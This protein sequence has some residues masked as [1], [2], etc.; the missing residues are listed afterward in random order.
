MARCYIGQECGIQDKLDVDHFGLENRT[1]CLAAFLEVLVAE[2]RLPINSKECSSWHYFLQKMPNI[3]K[4]TLMYLSVA[5]ECRICGDAE[6]ILITF[7]KIKRIRHFQS[8]YL[9][10]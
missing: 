10:I 4:K 3:V 2:G 5:F 9:F 1:T 6:L 7:L 8:V